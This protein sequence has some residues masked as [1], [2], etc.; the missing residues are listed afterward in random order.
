[1]SRIGATAL[2]AAIVLSFPAAAMGQSAGDEQYR[3][4]FAGQEDQ[5]Q[6]DGTTGQGNPAPAPAP[7]PTTTTAPTGSTTTTTAEPVATT[8]GTLPR[9]GSAGAW[10]AGF[11]LLLIAAGAGLRRTA[12]T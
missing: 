3:D 9:T 7:A 2:A 12:R 11:G 4:P 8:A 6:D 10:V 5:P 1:M